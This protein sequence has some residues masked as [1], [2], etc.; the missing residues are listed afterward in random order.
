METIIQDSF[1]E[2]GNVSVART[3][4]ATGYEWII[5]FESNILDVPTFTV[6]FT[7][8]AGS[9]VAHS[10]TEDSPK[11]VETSL[12]STITGLTTGV[13]YYI[14]VMAGS[15]VE[16][17]LTYSPATETFRHTCMSA[18]ALA[19]NLSVSPLSNTQVSVTFEKPESQ[20]SDID[21]YEMIWFKT[22]DSREKKVITFTDAES[23]YFKVQYEDEVSR[24]FD[25]A[26]A[27]ATDVQIGLNAM[28]SL[29]DV[30]V[31][32]ADD[33]VSEWIVEFTN[34]FGDVSDFTLIDD[35]IVPLQGGTYSNSVTQDGSSSSVVGVEPDLFGSQELTVDSSHCSMNYDGEDTGAC[36]E[37]TM[38]LQ[39]IMIEAENTAF[40]GGTFTISYNGQR[41]AE[42]SSS[43]S[44][45]D[46]TTALT[47]LVGEVL[48]DPI[49]VTV[50]MIIWDVHFKALSG[51]LGLLV[52]DGDRLTGED[53][54]ASVY[55]SVIVNLT[56]DTTNT[57]TL[58]FEGETSGDLKVTEATDQIALDEIVTAL[59]LMSNIGRVH[60]RWLT[61]KTKVEIT[62]MVYTGD[63][64]TF[65]A[66]PSS[67]TGLGS[68]VHVEHSMGYAPYRYI[69]GSP[70]MIQ[71]ITL[72]DTTG[73][74]TA[75]FNLNV[76]GQSIA[77]CLDWSADQNTVEG[78]IQT[79]LTAS[80]SN[81]KVMVETTSNSYNGNSHVLRFYH[82]H[83][84]A[85]MPII[86]F[87]NSCA[88]F[89]LS[90]PE[91]ELLLDYPAHGVA[92]N[93]FSADYVSLLPNTD[94]SFGVMA[95][96]ELGC[97]SFGELV[98]ITIPEIGVVPG[99]PVG[100]E[101][102]R[103]R[104]S[105]SLSVSYNAP[106]ETGGL[107][108]TRYE[109][110]WDTAK[111]FSSPAFEHKSIELK[112]EV[113]SVRTT[114]GRSSDRGGVFTLGLAGRLSADLDYNAS[115]DEVA[116]AV[117][118][119]SG[120]WSL[121]QNPIDVTKNAHPN[122]YEWLVTF[123][124]IDGDI[125]LMEIDDTTLAGY[126]AHGTVEEIT[127]GNSDITPGDF[128]FEVQCIETVAYSDIQVGSK[129]DLTF[130]G[131]TVA[132]IPYDTTAD[133]M[134]GFLVGLT[135]IHTANVELIEKNPTFPESGRIWCVTFTH[136][137]HEHEQGAGN[138][139][140]FEAD[141]S[142]MSGLGARVIVHEKIAG[143]NPLQ[144]W[145]TNL[146]A[147]TEYYVRVTAYNS[148]G[149]GIGSEVVSSV[150]LGQAS[151]PTTLSL[152]SVAAGQAI[153]VAWTVP[154]SNGGSDVLD[155]LVEHYESDN[156]PITE[157]QTI[158]TSANPSV[159][160][161]QAVV[162]T[163]TSG[164]ISGKFYLTFNGETTD[165]IDVDASDL[166]VATAL[167]R[168]STIG[169]VTVTKEKSRVPII[170]TSEPT[171]NAGTG[172]LTTGGDDFTSTDFF[173][174]YSE[175]WI[176]GE[177]SSYTIAAGSLFA[178]AVKLET[179][180]IPLTPA[181]TDL[182]I[183]KYGHGNTYFVEFTSHI[184]PQPAL[185]ATPSSSEWDGADIEL[186]V[187][188]ERN[189]LCETCQRGLVPIG[190]HFVVSY[191][192]DRSVPL[193]HDCS[194]DD[195]KNAL[196]SLRAIS[197]VSVEK[198]I[199]GF[200]YNWIIEFV[201]DL[202][203][204][205]DMV[206]DGDSLTG[207]H[208][209]VH[210]SETR[211]GDATGARAVTSNVVSTLTSNIASL[212]DG[213]KYIVRVRARTTEGLGQAAVSS[214]IPH[215]KPNAPINVS[216][217]AMSN[218]FAKIV[219][220]AGN[221]GG[222]E[223]DHY[224]IEWDMSSDFSNV[225]TSGYKHLFTTMQDTV[226][227]YY[228]NLPSVLLSSHLYYIRITA[229][230]QAGYSSEV[231]QPV[232]PS[233]RAPGS[234]INVVATVLSGHEIKV[235]WEASSVDELTYGGEGGYPLTHFLVQWDTPDFHS[236]P[237]ANT[238]E[239]SPSTNS[240]TIGSRDPMTGET[241]LTLVPGTVYA[242]RVIAVTNFGYSTP[243]EA[244]G[245][246]A[247]TADR[248]SF[249]PTLVSVESASSSQ[250]MSTYTVPANDGGETITKFKMQW[251]DNGDFTS[252]SEQE[253]KL[254]PERQALIIESDV[255][256]EIETITVQT[257]VTNEVQTI[258][259][260]VDGVD[261]VQ[262]ITTYT[263]P[264]VAE[265]QRIVIET[266]DVNHQQTIEASTA[267]RNEVQT[268]RTSGSNT[269]EVQEIV[270]NGDDRNEIQTVTINEVYGS[271]KEKFSVTFADP[272]TGRL[273]HGQSFTFGVYEQHNKYDVTMYIIATGLNVDGI[274]A[275][276][277]ASHIHHCAVLPADTHVNLTTKL[278]A[279]FNTVDQI[280]A[281]GVPPT[282]TV[283]MEGIG[284][285]NS[286]ITHVTTDV[287]NMFTLAQGG[288]GILTV[289]IDNTV[290]VP[291]D[292]SVFAEN[293]ID[294]TLSF[295]SGAHVHFV[296][297][298]T[299]SSDADPN[300]YIQLDVTKRG[301]DIMT[302]IKTYLDTTTFPA[303]HYTIADD[304]AGELTFT[305]S[306]GGSN[307]ITGWNLRPEIVLS[308]DVDGEDIDLS[309][310]FKLAFD[311]SDPNCKLCTV[312]ASQNTIDIN[313]DFNDS[314]T[315]MIASMKTALESM[316]NIVAGSVT[317]TGD[318]LY[319]S[320]VDVDDQGFMWTIE[321]SGSDVNGDVPQLVVHENNLVGDTTQINI[322]TP[323]PGYEI[324]NTQFKVVYDNAGSF[325]VGTDNTPTAFIHSDDSEINIQDK[326]N[327]VT[328]IAGAVVTF[329]DVAAKNDAGGSCGGKRISI[330]FTEVHANMDVISISDFTVDADGVGTYN[331]TTLDAVVDTATII[332]GE[333]IDGTFDLTIPKNGGLTTVVA[334]IASDS[335]ATDMKSAI[336]LALGDATTVTVSNPVAYK[337]ADKTMFN[338]AYT[339]EITFNDGIGNLPIITGDATS[340]TYNGHGSGTIAANLGGS[341]AVG[342]ETNPITNVEI[343]GNELGGKF[344]LKF[345]NSVDGYK[346]TGWINAA[347][348]DATIR[349]VLAHTDMA[350]YIDSIA[351]YSPQTTENRAKSVKW[352]M[353]FDSDN[354]G[355]FLE[356][357]TYPDE[358]PRI[359]IATSQS[360]TAILPEIT[361]VTVSTDIS[362]ILL[363]GGYIDINTSSNTVY[364]IV[365]ELE[366]QPAVA[367]ASPALGSLVSVD[368]IATDDQDAIAT[369]I[370]TE[371]G[372]A[373]GGAVTL[374]LTAANELEI[375]DTSNGVVTL[376]SPRLG[377]VAGLETC[378][379]LYGTL[380]TDVASLTIAT[381]REGNELGGKFRI[382]YG[383]EDSAD[384][385]WNV[386]EGA[387][388]TILQ[389]MG[390]IGDVTV[391]LEYEN[392][393]QT[394]SR[395]WSVTFESNVHDGT[396]H[397]NYY[398]GT[399]HSE[400]WGQNV[401]D[402]T[403]M[404]TISSLT[405]TY[406]S[407][408]VTATVNDDV[409]G[410]EPVGGD[411]H[412]VVDTRGCKTCFTKARTVSAAIRHDAPAMM[413]DATTA[414]RAIEESIEYILEDLSNIG[415]VEVSRGAVDTTTGGYV[416]MIT[417]LNDVLSTTSGGCSDSA[418]VATCLS[419]GDMPM[420]NTVTL[421][422]D[423]FVGSIKRFE[424]VRGNVLR[425]TFTLDDTVDT[426]NPMDWNI[427][428]ADLKTRLEDDITSIG[429]V[430]VSRD[431]LGLYGAFKWTVTFTENPGLIPLGAG[432]VNDLVVTD[433]L[434]TESA[435]IDSID[436]KIQQITVP[437]GATSENHG[438]RIDSVK[439]NGKY[440][441][442]FSA[443]PTT[444]DVET[445]MA[446]P[447]NDGYTLVLISGFAGGDANTVM[448]GKLDTALSDLSGTPFDVSTAGAV[449]TVTDKSYGESIS[450]NGDGEFGYGVTASTKTDTQEITL[451][452]LGGE[453][454]MVEKAVAFDTDCLLFR[455]DAWT[456]LSVGGSTCTS[457]TYVNVSG[458][459]ATDIATNT[460]AV[461]G[462]PALEYT[463][464]QD[465][466]SVIVKR[467]T[468]G[469]FDIFTEE[470]NVNFMFRV[471]ETREGSDGCS[472]CAL[473]ATTNKH[474]F[475]ELQKGSIGLTGIFT[476]DMDIS[477]LGPQNIDVTDSVA[478][479][480]TVINSL[481]SNVEVYVSRATFGAGWDHTTVDVDG[482]L[483]G[484]VYTVSFMRNAG[485]FSGQ[486]YPAGSGNVN[487]L[488]IDDTLSGVNP[489][490]FIS[491]ITHG[492]KPM[493]DGFELTFNGDTTVT[494]P[495]DSPDSD[496]M[497]ALDDLTTI[498]SVTVTRDSIATQLIDGVVTANFNAEKV[499]FT[500]TDPTIDVMAY[501]FDDDL[502]RI[503]ET[504]GSSTLLSNE[505]WGGEGATKLTGSFSITEASA[506][507]ITSDDLTEV[508]LPGHE[509][510][511]AGE[512]Y[513]VS[514]NGVSI[515]TLAVKIVEDNYPLTAG[516]YKATIN[517]VASGCI[518]YSATAS[519]M[520]LALVGS[521]SGIKVPSKRI[522]TT[523]GH[524][525]IEYLILF[526]GSSWT[527]DSEADITF[528]HEFTG[529]CTVQSHG[530]VPTM[531]SLPVSA[532]IYPRAASGYYMTL[533][534]TIS[535][536]SAT[537][538]SGYLNDFKF[539]V[540]DISYL[541]QE[542][543]FT[544]VSAVITDYY[545]MYFH[546]D[547]AA[548]LKYRFYFNN[549]ATPTMPKDGRTEVSVNI[550][551]AFTIADVL[552]TLQTAV[553]G[554][555]GLQCN[556]SGVDTVT[557]IDTVGGNVALSPHHGNSNDLLFTLTVSVTG[558]NAAAHIW[559]GT[560]SDNTVAT[561]FPYVSKLSSKLYRENGFQWLITFDSVLGDLPVMSV[562]TPAM[563]MITRA[564]VGDDYR[565]GYL[566]LTMFASNLQLGIPYHVRVAAYSTVGL[567]YGDWSNVM[568]GTPVALPS[569]P[570]HVTVSPLLHN[571]EVQ[572]VATFAKH[573][574]EVQVIK[575]TAASINEIQAI[576]TYN[577][578]SGSVFG[579]DFE[580]QFVAPDGETVSTL[581]EVYKFDIESTTAIST[582]T[583]ALTV[584]G[585]DTA[586]FSPGETALNVK[587]A[588]EGVAITPPD[589]SVV[590]TQD[591]FNYHYTIV[592]LSS[593]SGTINIT[594]DPAK[595]VP[596]VNEDGTTIT[597]TLT[598][599]DV[600]GDVYFSSN[601]SATVMKTSIEKFSSFLGEV[602]V[603]QSLPDKNDGYTWTISYE[604][605][606]G[607]L[608]EFTF[609]YRIAT[610]TLDSEFEVST[611]MDGNE[612]GGDFVLLFDDGSGSAQSTASIP[613]LAT[614]SDI[615]TALENLGS[616]PSDSIIVDPNV[617][618][619]GEKGRT[620][621]VRFTGN[622]GDLPEM[623]Y[624]SSLTGSGVEIKITESIKGN[625]IG[626]D[627][628]LT[629][630]GIQSDPIS[631]DAVA[632]AVDSGSNG[633]SMQE[634]IQ[635]MIS[636]GQVEVTKQSLDVQNGAI[637]DVTFV[638][639]DMPGDLPLLG[640][641]SS[642]TGVEAGVSVWQTK[643]GTHP[644]GTS[645]EVCFETPLSDGGSPLE[646]H[647]VEWDTAPTFNSGAYGK[648]DVTNDEFLYKIQRISTETGDL[649]ESVTLSGDT[650]SVT[651]TDANIG[652]VVSPISASAG[653]TVS[654][655][656][657]GDSSLKEIS[658]ITA[659]I[660][661]GSNL[662]DSTQITFYA[663]TGEIFDLHFTSS[664]SFAATVG[665]TLVRVECGLTVA[666]TPGEV[667]TAVQNTIAKIH[668][669]IAGTFTLQ[670]GD[671]I[672]P[673]MSYDI[674]TQD[675]RQIL[676]SVD[677]IN[678]VS[679]TKEVSRKIHFGSEVNVY[680]GQSYIDTPVSLLGEIA[681]G[682]TIWVNGYEFTVHDTN[683][684]SAS[685]LSLGDANNSATFSN[686]LGSDATGVEIQSVAHG[687][688]WAVTFLSVTSSEPL[689][690]LPN[691]LTPS[692]VT[693]VS[694]RVGDTNQHGCL[695]IDGLTMGVEYN[696]RVSSANKDSVCALPPCFGTSSDVVLVTPKQ[697]PTA[698][699]LVQA[700]AI[701]STD[702]EVIWS[703]PAVPG[704]AG[705]TS[706]LIEID[707][708]QTF[709]P[710]L[711]STSI[712]GGDISGIDP[713]ETV[714]TVTPTIPAS[715]TVYV[716]ISADNG[717]PVSQFDS[718]NDNRN[719]E[720]V[721]PVVLADKAPDAPSQ[722]SLAVIDDDTLRTY[723]TLATREG[724]QSVGFI[725]VHYDVNAA[726]TSPTTNA[727][728]A[729]YARL[730]V[731][732]MDRLSSLE[733]FVHD[734]NGLETGTVYNVR[735]AAENIVG[736][737]DW[738]LSSP[739]SLAPASAPGL[740]QNVVVD[741]DSARATP[742]TD[743]TVNWES[744]STDGGSPVTGFNVEYW[745]TART[746][747]VQRIQI[748]DV[749]GIG[750]IDTNSFT[751]TYLGV[752][753]GALNKDSS[754]HDVREALMN[755][756]SSGSEPIGNVEVS[757]I[758]G[759]DFI[760]WEVTFVNSSHNDGTMPL[761]KFVRGVGGIDS[762][763]LC[764]GSTCVVDSVT[765]SIIG[766]HVNGLPEVQV[767]ETSV[768]AGGSIDG[769]FTV[770]FNGSEESEFIPFNCDAALMASILE[771]I[772]TIGQ[773]EVNVTG[774]DANGYQWAITFL[775]NVG[776]LPD[777]E[778]A[779]DKLTGAGVQTITVTGGDYDDGAFI[780]GETPT[781]YH[782]TSVDSM[783]RSLPISG[784]T[785]GDSYSIR[786][787]AVNNYG[788]GEGSITDVT[789]V[790]PPKQSPGVPLN[791]DL[792]VKFGSDH[793]I[794]VDYDAPASDGGDDVI[795]YRIEYSAGNANFVSPGVK[796]VR[797]SNYPE[798]AT[799]T[800]EANGVQATI[801]V[802]VTRNGVSETVSFDVDAVASNAD[803]TYPTIGKS[804]EANME[805]LAQISSVSVT[806][807]TIIGT[808]YR[809]TVTFLDDGPVTVSPTGAVTSVVDTLVI[810]Q[811]P[812]DYDCLGAQVIGDG[813]CNVAPC[814]GLNLDIDYYVR[815]MAINKIDIGN[816][817]D[818]P[819]P[820]RAMV[821]PTRPTGVTV[822]V[823]S[824]SELRV[825]WAPPTSNGGDAIDKYLIEW[826]TL[827]DFSV[828]GNHE[829]TY[830]PDWDSSVYGSTSI[831]YVIPQLTSGTVYYIRVKAHN[832]Q[833]YS[834]PQSSSPT[835]EYPRRAPSAPVNVVVQSTSQSMITVSFTSPADNGGD[836]VTLYKIEWDTTSAFNSLNTLPNKG[837][838][839]V[840]ASEHSSYTIGSSS[841]PLTTGMN[842][843][844]RV[845][846]ANKEGY[847]LA[848]FANVFPTTCSYQRPGLVSSLNAIST[849][850]GE[851]TVTWS[852]PIVPYHG[853]PCSGMV[854]TPGQCPDGM[855][856]QNQ[857]DGGTPIQRYEV[858]VS[859]NSDFSVKE[860]AVITVSA[861]DASFTH[862]FTSLDSA[863]AAG[864]Y[865]GVY[866]E[867]TI[868]GYGNRCNKG[869]D[870]CD[871]SVVLVACP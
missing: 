785:A 565:S 324:K 517:G 273:H 712:S 848:K 685:R 326:L 368:L 107:A 509:I 72:K 344:K 638:D 188:T 542:T 355:G 686:Y 600:G 321:F 409:Q 106:I 860:S 861:N 729:G 171:F 250:L 371:L 353:E 824:S 286:P 375:T 162:M 276:N 102:G 121:D 780:V 287:V 31:T 818:A 459:T 669:V 24:R 569:A 405:K 96:N 730:D 576:H 453:A 240:F 413:S 430:L 261:E 30:T 715:S 281:S 548:D 538:V 293:L 618:V 735:V 508:V 805:K 782:V 277:P 113:Q 145:L 778:V 159:R 3:T 493:A 117:Q 337:P 621:T 645:V 587:N 630:A 116:E 633:L 464:T 825:T 17:S 438:F 392:P 795:M 123:I 705:I 181:P 625:E 271:T 91:Q 490:A 776:D 73:I 46:L 843:Y 432:D 643:T 319:E 414:G 359:V 738:S 187:E 424:E 152:T 836:A 219:W 115:A 714:I 99:T 385:N 51:P 567:G 110:D 790:T 545:D 291:V 446:L 289:K 61:A 4:L 674:N 846:A 97:G 540:K 230:N 775:N 40:V 148:I 213:T 856:R 511:L 481:H 460:A 15:M 270:L 823:E 664:P 505:L 278:T 571:D 681:R 214:V 275:H 783:T 648:V 763:T 689:K 303:N 710:A 850:A 332:D 870:S 852:P 760:A 369:K 515:R 483:G 125:A 804:V 770:I 440:A 244:T 406:S 312:Q 639:K 834:E 228:W 205:N 339:W 373:A 452:F 320:G 465:G 769:F 338:G 699:I 727:L 742:I 363:H 552:T 360:G 680:N 198:F 849:T 671:D 512:T 819:A 161:V 598:T 472:G 549:A 584:N 412:I 561:N 62:M 541:N 847:G 203:D 251:D 109:I 434:L 174:D 604:T 652:V 77:S 688:T 233:Y 124:G 341:I 747:E 682:D 732:T 302:E 361:T 217:I 863:H 462:L 657:V 274:P 862:T 736:T 574:D 47:P 457:T 322:A 687:N 523:G 354:Q 693:T 563:D 94:Y 570:F 500:A 381:T 720:V 218:T 402:L 313:V 620:W 706:Y 708:S 815:V 857:A 384:I 514:N 812:L 329:T 829:V 391:K 78:S 777:I 410:T 129:F 197:T 679:I 675:M 69:I 1:W 157:I 290:T 135:T 12:Q 672:I 767:I 752:G 85:S 466:D 773:V 444:V 791:V 807:D 32:K 746:Y 495:Y 646:V 8:I 325:P 470:T 428:A 334:T 696:V 366:D 19:R 370:D 628:A 215:T 551:G 590:H 596:I 184:G 280:D 436:F 837:S 255:I 408:T 441:V 415:N 858:W 236:E 248:A 513:T 524:T 130:E 132:D 7:G 299:P 725:H 851:L 594:F 395:E 601:V 489:D 711:I 177:T 788:L 253:V 42:L 140:L 796:D 608:N 114:F 822:S 429:R 644:S 44:A 678:D 259:T 695:T 701:S 407:A 527:D 871:G 844:I 60:A 272:T 482:T 262:S 761:I 169:D 82:I 534:S 480:N 814:N 80:G 374:N 358:C 267:E 50:G 258:T 45:T 34:S 399:K 496:V 437:D 662:A 207:P 568:V 210:V 721:K 743:L 141:S 753:S 92:W 153:D 869:G 298:G 486:S 98:T 104:T 575:T 160:D 781:D 794:L 401:G 39:T 372:L 759:T 356:D 292:H 609:V 195:M 828:V 525:Y 532:G 497:N 296:D 345:G 223:I 443:A 610:K 168:L 165:A 256:N 56:G 411:F 698:P 830:I 737:S 342:D 516:A 612:I 798:R 190:G 87:D 553:S 67:F 748:S 327:A 426:T 263:D 801:D 467:S 283:E 323:T 33:A 68:S 394:N 572:R 566:P 150:P 455:N 386:S 307:D 331:P 724:G 422:S 185:V 396:D 101:V 239:L 802:D 378:N 226:G 75:K 665:A 745:N 617:I 22:D 808:T 840:S 108:V 622:A 178:G 740:V 606:G 546:I 35:E 383:G 134:R 419:P 697:V 614:D 435:Y 556:L 222:A 81:M 640:S 336:E 139:S 66:Q 611:L 105:S 504:S 71:T 314:D 666:T 475:G 458:L 191:D 537:G 317:V 76:N 461:V 388:Q 295:G 494:I 691:T 758:E 651:F 330:E 241:A 821:V 417:F 585:Q 660:A 654:Q 192:G 57:F 79:A 589:V 521:G 668:G 28:V 771:N 474:V 179:G 58:S 684:F 519:E 118:F 431:R 38:D 531:E 143:T 288:V 560:E 827:S 592:A 163:A 155:Y 581:N 13:E 65:N 677:S 479:V 347:D 29:P 400:S 439:G 518:D 316:G 245:S 762:L 810:G 772:S 311:T 387:L 692:G 397:A 243:T 733:A 476:V 257:E 216:I 768:S 377:G 249:A 562:T 501:I 389:N 23:G 225:A 478:T 634:R 642:L 757:R 193:A 25:V 539:R 86:T 172:D 787:I 142:N 404:G 315:T 266:E 865:V 10:Y 650:L 189:L 176:G 398:S 797:C 63:I 21:H 447:D 420:L 853:T 421:T 390:T 84:E 206:V 427:D 418:N 673:D 835:N 247:T 784:L 173:G 864:Y 379:W 806:R 530:A 362:P 536:P 202:G 855:G 260:Q 170:F 839:V 670:Y 350:T 726:F 559:L 310:K 619:D 637:W 555:T 503:G 450:A 868:G 704:G 144:V 741:V 492:S 676:E 749:N 707:T 774:D 111:S 297:S 636:I 305:A 64:R 112:H 577:S 709:N 616:I 88:G 100:V 739:L 18:P 304:G 416:W 582:G 564:F 766:N 269:Y 180:A 463:L 641:V 158:T 751:L 55:R 473:T 754:I 833:G 20:G 632:T 792:D 59:E 264:V 425:G 433:T 803:E 728:I 16:G 487:A 14:R 445:F 382:S 49:E 41:T 744:P 550:S 127:K 647:R 667:M 820:Q 529:D 186:Y 624:V 367:V 136:L 252:P 166:E 119:I 209:A 346:T 656:Q 580:L 246:P 510:V 595:C 756:G 120:S 242:V 750:D 154:A 831:H 403:K 211:T 238:I 702:V 393:D 826:S 335:S 194:A 535:T 11:G 543:T 221:T 838:A 37:G 89:E 658:K 713:F 232:Q 816:H 471:E 95:C 265:V 866:A 333:Y 484:Y 649:F 254:V 653:F 26:S 526:T 867:N 520:E 716:R 623:Q 599:D 48:V 133:G 661:D 602:N 629:Y 328:Q 859:K 468:P 631:F 690:T 703:T 593:N 294:Q 845:S 183:F 128:T 454:D 800:I 442:F 533:S 485:S 603:L 284:T 196:E 131:E 694:V 308:R 842:Y 528:S 659:T 103:F 151:A 722:V 854:G 309:G 182:Q 591:G 93:Q 137:A 507:I 235:D 700:N 635:D 6:D 285:V 809:W 343:D 558:T 352:Y 663:S 655:E 229:H 448:A 9:N 138:L 627:F 506:D 615:K 27:S 36:I 779:T 149:H 764:G 351:A 53:V 723:I 376:S 613:F 817:A 364:R 224:L 74:T 146:I 212:T 578:G 586:C 199:N 799:Y 583:F 268:I 279:C 469:H 498:G 167:K 423:E 811:S 719:W 557:I 220:S 451:T 573:I 841:N 477:G 234:P 122:G 2:I 813:V 83:D 156:A 449:V 832:S 126:N 204:L 147:G 626:S 70:A 793:E 357:L 579:S 231:V 348:D 340:L 547:T 789:T 522:Y 499:L 488:I 90:Y 282:V 554:Q 306:M 456:I 318:W 175:Y 43:I 208:A 380:S 301:A 349:G 717:V 52:I 544:A 164:V 502:L 237:P 734:L 491:T 607:N 588:I 200:G 718:S 683:T 300:Y 731:S 54:V 786:V 201:D 765:R 755:I 365:F 605:V 5:T 597:P 227:P